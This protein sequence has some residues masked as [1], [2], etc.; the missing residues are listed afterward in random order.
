MLSRS[1]E[2]LYWMG[3]YDEDSD[4]DWTTPLRLYNAVDAYNRS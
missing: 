4:G 1:A 3:R 2:G